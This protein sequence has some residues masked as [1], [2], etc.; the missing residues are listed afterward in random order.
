MDYSNVRHHLNQNMQLP[1]TISI[2]YKSYCGTIVGEYLNWQVV[3]PLLALKHDYLLH[4]MLAMSA[5]E[6]A[7]FSTDDEDRI[8]YYV[9]VALQYQSTAS[10]GLRKELQKHHLCEP[11]GALRPFFDP[12]N[13]WPR[14]STLLTPAGREWQ[15]AGLHDDVPSSAKRTK[16]DRGH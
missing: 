7:A 8:D 12:P 13:P 15:Y 10:S 5:L 14:N 11:P 1:L 9:N 2:R 3:V 6:I 16:H 4:G